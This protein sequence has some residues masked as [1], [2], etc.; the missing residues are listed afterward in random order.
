MI[1]IRVGTNNEIAMDSNRNFEGKMDET[2]YE[3]YV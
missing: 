3:T 1:D 2:L